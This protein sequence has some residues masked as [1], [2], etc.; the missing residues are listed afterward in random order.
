[1]G[2]P[3]LDRN[4]KPIRAKRV[5]PEC[6]HPKRKVETNRNGKKFRECDTCGAFLGF[7]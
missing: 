5:K 7:I 4:K 2:T 3:K 1:M 6:Q